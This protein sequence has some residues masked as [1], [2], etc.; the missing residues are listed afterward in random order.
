[1]AARPSTARPQ[2]PGWN[3]DLRWT[4]N[5][6]MDM[7]MQDVIYP[8]GIHYNSEGAASAPLSV[9]EVAMMLLMDSLTDKP[10]WHI[11]VFDDDVAETW[12]TD[13][14]A[15]AWPNDVLWKRIAN[16]H[17]MRWEEPWQPRRPEHILDKECVDYCIHE[18]R[19][20]A[21]HF[22]N[23]GITPTLDATFSIAK[24][25]VLVS[26]GLRADLRDAFAQLQ[27]DQAPNPNWYPDSEDTVQNLVDPSMY[28]LV[29][30]RSRF[31]PDEVVGVK[32]AID[33]FAGKGNVIPRRPEWGEE[34]RGRTGRSNHTP[35]E[36]DTG[37]G[38]S[39]IHRSYWST[40]YQ[41]LPAN[42]KFTG[43][44]GVE[45][46]SY[47]N[48]LHPTKHR[49]IYTTIEKLVETAL[50]MWDQCLGQYTSIWHIG[51]GR[52]RP[53]LTPDDAE[54]PCFKDLAEGLTGIYSNMKL[55]NWDPKSPSEMLAREAAAKRAEQQPEQPGASTEEGEDIDQE[56][57]ED[58]EFEDEDRWYEIRKP[59]QL[60]LP[61]FSPSEVKY[62]VFPSRSLREQF[63]DTGLQIIVKVS[64]IELR[65][66]QPEFAVEDWH[67]EGMMNEHIVGTALYFLDSENIT[68]SHID[69]RTITNPHIDEDWEEI[70][71]DP[72]QWLESIYGV[73]LGGFHN[74][75]CLQNYGSV[76][77]PPGRLLAFPNVFQHR[78]SGFRL[79]DP[80]KPGH[81]RVITL[82]LVDPFTRIISTAN[83]PPQQ[84]DWWADSAFGGLTNKQSGASSSL[85]PEIAQLLAEKGFGGDKLAEALA[86][87]QLAEP[88]LP[89]ELLSIV[90]KEFGDGLPMSREE[91]E[92]HRLKM[93]DYLE[94]FHG[95]ALWN[96]KS[97]EYNFYEED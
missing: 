66:E 62:A 65:P 49:G 16:H 15:L 2:Y 13:M 73:K 78:A 44:G 72:L 54:Y 39:K 70:E 43:D 85:P 42:V 19:R 96:W 87:G 41:L 71:E 25:D 9:R 91:A 26:E 74:S 63:N 60:P 14:E 56:D 69:F 5:G 82:S 29:Y 67:V 61:A 35:D 4:T 95:Q 36:G 18:L 7:H 10:D 33:R 12:K 22:E 58:I 77:T 20:K 84:A 40:I 3:R 57:S 37:P 59:I 97:V 48:N 52:H 80:S 92:E 89:P 34:P 90:R 21:C 17:N 6:H 31:L 11:K 30:G 79:A 83:V 8:T 27:A 50:P 45:F 64:S 38:G 75:S 86:A 81:C 53:R 68:D 23:T 1:M 76:L 46:T 94:A 55:G 24:S 32:D 51:A 28:P 93:K 47:I 88:K